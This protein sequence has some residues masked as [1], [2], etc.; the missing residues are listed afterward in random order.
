MP[1][2][3]S[4]AE[5]I[6]IRERVHPEF[7]DDACEVCA[8]FS[9]TAAMIMLLDIRAD[10]DDEPRDENGRWTSGGDGSESAPAIVPLSETDSVG[11]VD[12][13]VALAVETTAISQTIKDTSSKVLTQYLKPE[14]T[15]HDTNVAIFSNRSI[16][17]SAKAMV[18]RD[19]ASRMDSKYD[20]QL[21][22]SISFD[23]SD[24]AETGS[25]PEPQNLQVMSLF[26]KDDVW[27]VD[28]LANDPPSYQGKLSENPDLEKYFGKNNGEIDEPHVTTGDDSMVRTQLRED[29]VSNLVQ[30]WAQSSN[31]HNP[32]SLAIQESAA[33]EFGLTNTAPWD[34]EEQ[35]TFQ[36][37]VVSNPE[38]KVPLDSAVQKDLDKNGDMYQAFLRAQYDN[39]QQFFKDNG[40]SQVTAYRGFDFNGQHEMPH[41]ADPEYNDIEQD[42]EEEENGIAPH[43]DADVPLRPLSSFSYDPDSAQK[44]AG[45]EGASIAIVIGGEVP[46]SRIL[47][48]AVT[49]NG[50]LRER[51]MVLLGGTD[52]WTV[53]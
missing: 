27:R 3:L 34:T 53:R 13:K 2:L 29:A 33:K 25:E 17:V 20:N 31:D 28:P 44:F 16:E 32:Y 18:A 9:T 49:G 45:M 22:G 43:W 24:S 30:T 38:A 15:S 37:W 36:D 42:E 47:S 26:T 1:R 48:T 11:D 19:I 21:L 7:H 5:I 41:W 52:K 46:A 23:K 35:T 40:I 8:V 14:T 51:E 4:T 10:I 6:E 50:C 12:E 39:T